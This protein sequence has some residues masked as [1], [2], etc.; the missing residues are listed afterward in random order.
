MT[1]KT[2]KNPVT[3]FKFGQMD[4]NMKDNSKKAKEMEREDTLGLMEESMRD[5]LKMI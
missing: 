4:Q 3:E 5:N 2:T 1:I